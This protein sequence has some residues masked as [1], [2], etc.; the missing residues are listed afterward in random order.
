MKL[1]DFEAIEIK[2][3]KC[4]GSFNRSWECQESVEKPEIEI[5]KCQGSF[6]RSWVSRKCRETNMPDGLSEICFIF[7]WDML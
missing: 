7:A 6:N 2:I 4:Q 1:H 3:W 5:W